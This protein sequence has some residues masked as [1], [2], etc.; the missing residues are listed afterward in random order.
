[1]ALLGGVLLLFALVSSHVRRLPLSSSSLYLGFGLALGPLGLGWL[2]VD[3]DTQS[4]WLEHI[5]EVAVIFSLFV[6]GMKLRLPFSHPSWRTVV[7]LTGPLM[8]F[9]IAGV[10]A[11]AYLVLG[12]DAATSCL[13]GAVLAP[14]D[15]VLASAVS[16]KEAAD[17]DATR[18][19]LSGEA[20]LNDGMA[21][22]FVVLALSLAAEGAAGPWM[23]KWAF[24]RLVWGIPA[25][26]LIGYFL[27]RVV[28]R[29]A[30][31]YKS[32]T[33]N[34]EAT[35]DFL[36][37]ALVLLSY[38]AAEVVHAWGFLAVFAAGLG[39]RSAEL[40]V[41]K[42]SP[43]PET[44]GD[45]SEIHP[46]AEDLLPGKVRDSSMNEPAVAAGALV[47]E[48]L[49]FGATAE[50]F[51][52]LFLVVGVGAALASYWDIR[53][54]GV[55]FVLFFV[56]RPLGAQLLLVSTPTSTTQRWLLGWFG[57]R[58]IGSLYY[59]AHAANQPSGKALAS[60]IAALTLSVV[61]MSILVH[62]ISAT[63]LLSWYQ[64]ASMRRARSPGARSLGAREL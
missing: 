6:S 42:E 49:S 59:L 46:P 26:L 38:V 41:V 56:L 9:C 31:R 5:T 13:L 17:Q 58:G 18:F 14:T 63:P 22:P 3:F 51:L 27:G 57:V 48:G 24:E 37:V 7:K 61:A 62:G 52:E 53:A 36:V 10:A 43:H 21:F 40:A 28:S 33:R 39:F 25:A 47:A 50:R 2:H 29:T 60:D 1:M 20:G 23:W 8:A 12:F 16:V 15:P 4:P 54:I 32:Q 45:A 11:F 44:K 30:M 55:A 64:R 34:A 35:S 19:G